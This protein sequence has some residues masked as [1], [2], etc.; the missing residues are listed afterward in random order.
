[1]SAETPGLRIAVNV[2]RRDFDLEIDLELEPGGRLAL[3][4]PSGAGK[5][6]ILRTVAGLV[7]PDSGLITV[8]GLT[9][10]DSDRGM[11]VPPEERRCGYVP[12]DYSLFPNMTVLGNVGFGIRKA[13]AGERRSR[14]ARLLELLGIGGLADVHPA[15]LSGGERQRVALA[16]ALATEP[17]VFLL[18]EPLSAL[19]PAT[20][21]QAIPV[22]DRALTLSNVP[23]L[24]VTH[25]RQEAERLADSTVIIDR[26]KVSETRDHDGTGSWNQR[27]G[28]VSIHRVVRKQ[29]D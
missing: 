10:F 25:S 16:R 1:M 6:T 7:K 17:A 13:K 11:D 23:T 19:D 12:Q 28:P 24:I 15:G 27:S 22:L 4:G 18:D 9:V 14:A 20:R 2:S 3:V 21:G 29:R 26:G 5:T 8:A